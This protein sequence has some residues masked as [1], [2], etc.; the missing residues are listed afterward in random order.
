MYSNLRDSSQLANHLD[1]A[2]VL[3]IQWQHDIQFRLRWYRDFC[4]CTAGVMVELGIFLVFDLRGLRLAR[5]FGA[6]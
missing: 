5:G 2:F 1:R 3:Y 6:G 4:C